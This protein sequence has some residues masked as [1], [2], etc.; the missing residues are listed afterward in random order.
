MD[1]SDRQE[2]FTSF[3]HGYRLDEAAFQF[4]D[5]SGDTRN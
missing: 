4:V 5:F 3:D 1:T 2:A